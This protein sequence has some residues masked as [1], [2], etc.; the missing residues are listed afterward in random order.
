VPSQVP[1][2]PLQ[3]S[4]SLLQLAPSCPPDGPPQVLSHVPHVALQQSPSVAHPP[5]LAAQPHVPPAHVPLQ[6]SLA[7]PQLA[8]SCE[9]T[10][11][12]QV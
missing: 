9:P 3:Q 4:P 11:P 5:P 8:P 6:H 2:D 7:E 10:A 1:H 12:P